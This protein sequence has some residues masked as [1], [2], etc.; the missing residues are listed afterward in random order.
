MSQADGK[1]ESLKLAMEKINN[2]NLYERSKL[3]SLGEPDNGLL[4]FKAFGKEYLISDKTY[5][6]IYKN[7]VTEP[8][9]DEKILILHYLLSEIPYKQ[10]E[11]Q[12]SFREFSGGQ[13]Y[14]TP[15]ISRTAKPLAKKIGNNLDL[16][17]KNLKKYNYEEIKTGDFAAKI[18][19]IG[20][21]FITLVY[22]LG[23]DEFEP[24]VDILFDEYT[25]HVYK[26]EDAVYIASKICISLLY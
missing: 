7:D 19:T 14:W 16:L 9:D 6:I 22:H 23:D 8:K 12:I 5:K 17:R 11:T 15:F 4:T 21:I 10:S 20:N 24:E 1:K 13:F 2:V 18:H 3:L 25:K 26:A